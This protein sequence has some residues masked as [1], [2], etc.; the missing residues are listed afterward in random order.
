MFLWLTLALAGTPD[1]DENPGDG[2]A[3]AAQTRLAEY[4][5][6]SDE[7]AR[8]A[9]RNNWTA[10]DRLLQQ[11]DDIGHPHTLAVLKIAAEANTVEGNVT[12]AL[13]RLTT[14]SMLDPDPVVTE[15]LATL[16]A[17]YGPVFLA[18]DLPANY[19]LAPQSMP[20]EPERRAAVQFAV[21]QMREHGVYDGVLPHGTYVFAPYGVTSGP[22]VFRIDV[23]GDRRSIDLRT[24]EVITGADRRKRARI[25]RKIE[26][27]RLKASRK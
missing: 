26:K 20:F 17:T 10:V 9:K 21:E 25:D 1:P 27:A 13:G 12:G 19:R 14:A 3:L 15:R 16:R 2:G 18:A 8:A 22:G 4:R 6:L 7:L 5:R 11:L 23:R 24:H